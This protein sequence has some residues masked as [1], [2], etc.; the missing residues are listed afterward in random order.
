MSEFVI[1]QAA[2]GKKRGKGKITGATLCYVK[3][4]EGAFK[5]GS[6]TEKE[7][8][9]DVVVDKATAK[10]FKKTF[11]KNGIREIDTP[12]F[13]A[14]YKCAPPFPDADEQFVLKLK[15]KTAMSKDG[16]GLNA[17]DPIPYEW[18]TRPKLFVRAEGGV[19]DVTMTT[20]AAN[21]SKGVVGFAILDNGEFGQ[22]PQLTGVLVEELIEYEGNAGGAS[23]DFGEVVG[24]LNPGSGETQQKASAGQ[25]ED[26]DEEEN[27]DIPFDSEDPED[28]GSPF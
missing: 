10:A 24:G 7:Y 2:D 1:E 20:L 23:S 18:N 6:K 3:L 27:S 28:T 19:K 5:Y 22:S 25:V 17:G 13:E 14:K 15:S 4:Q 8:T 11:A 12:E 9:V 21:G 16:G 26:S